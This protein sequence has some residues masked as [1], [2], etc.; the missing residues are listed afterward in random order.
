MG[1]DILGIDI[2]EVD[3]LGIDIPAP[4]LLFHRVKWKIFIFH[5]WRSHE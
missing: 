4:A 1:I 5:E 2:L 3:I